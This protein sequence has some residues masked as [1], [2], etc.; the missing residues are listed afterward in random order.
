MVKE[1]SAHINL[2]VAKQK[3]DSIPSHKR[4]HI[5]T[6]SNHNNS[7]SSCQS[8]S[9][10]GRAARGEP[11]FRSCHS[12]SS[13]YEYKP[14]VPP[15]VQNKLRKLILQFPDGIW[16]TKLPA[17]FRKMF[18]ED[19]S[20]EKY[21]YRSL[22]EMCS[23]LPEIFHYLQLTS[24]DFMLYDKNKPIPSLDQ[25]DKFT[26]LSKDILKLDWSKGPSLIPADVLCL[27]DEIPRGFPFHA[28][29]GDVVDVSV[30]EIEDI[31]KFWIYMTCGEIKT[32]MDELQ[33]LF[34]LSR[35]RYVI[36]QILMT[37]GLYCTVFCGNEYHRCIIIDLLP[38]TPDFIKVLFIDYG[39]VAKVHRSK[40]W[41][42]PK[43]FGNVPCQAIKAKLSS[44]HPTIATT[45]TV[46][47]FRRLITN[48]LLVAKI[49]KVDVK[50]HTLEI[51]L[52]DITNEENIFY[53]ND[54]L[55]E[56]GYALY[57]DQMITSRK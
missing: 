11:S 35:N 56:E 53:I 9:S 50:N 52:A 1:K 10:N 36:P 14:K 21:N 32:L 4:K 22:I 47:R 5:K 41:F 26:D 45:E 55:V 3:K 17:E 12:E 40:V 19:I 31:T 28:Q 16:C 37:E 34:R 8:N 20:Y 13:S 23:D 33:T 18:K 30:G 38:K 51:Y 7:A 29:I 6:Y 27:S 42:L 49:T 57:I 43:Q 2:L 48:R 24:S 25:N 15:H 46:S 44:I 54:V 39:D